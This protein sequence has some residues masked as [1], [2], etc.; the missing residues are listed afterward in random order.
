ML[1]VIV[2]LYSYYCVFSRKWQKHVFLLLHNVPFELSL[3]PE[4]GII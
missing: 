3:E 4:M 2:D 1:V